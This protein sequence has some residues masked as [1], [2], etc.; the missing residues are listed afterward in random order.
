MPSAAFMADKGRSDDRRVIGLSYITSMPAK[1]MFMKG[2][3]LGAKVLA[4]RLL[5]LKGDSYVAYPQQNLLALEM[6][7]D[8]RTIQRYISELCDAGLIWSIRSGHGTT[9]RYGF[10]DHEAW[11]WTEEDAAAVRLLMA[12]H[13]AECQRIRLAGT[14]PK[15]ATKMSQGC[16]KNVAVTKMS[17]LNTRQECRLIDHQHLTGMSVDGTS[18]YIPGGSGIENEKLNPP[19]CVNLA[20][21][22]V[23]T[24]GSRDLDISFSPKEN[25][26]NTTNL[27]GNQAIR[28]AKPYATSNISEP[29]GFTDPVTLSP[30]P[31]TPLPAAAPLTG[32]EDES[33]EPQLGFSRWNRTKGLP[34]LNAEAKRWIEHV[35]EQGV[36]DIPWST[37]EA[38]LEAFVANDEMKGR[39]YPYRAFWKNPAAWAPNRQES[40]QNAPGRFQG[41]RTPTPPPSAAPCPASASAVAPYVEMWNRDNPHSE[42]DATIANSWDWKE[43]IGVELF[44]KEFSRIAQWCGFLRDDCGLTHVNLPW[45]LRKQHGVKKRNWERLIEG[46]FLP[47][48][49]SRY[50]QTREDAD[51]Q[52][53]DSDEVFRDLASKKLPPR[54]PEEIEIS[55]QKDIERK[56]KLLAWMAECRAKTEAKRQAELRAVINSP[57][58]DPFAAIAGIDAA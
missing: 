41:V 32:Y 56:A 19:A 49:W 23:A 18:D 9:G 31:P 16:D 35:H 8:V 12:K 2:I 42:T 7:V 11:Q 55:R 14:R 40:R 53:R 44:R 3:S 34:K 37:V 45:V 57:D 5:T 46:D 29:E 30:L 10:H 20:I 39:S 4:A 15:G 58:Y 13:K 1:L 28:E 36:G 25:Q 33:W 54:T 17:P 24:N 22:S 50:P 27:K 38:A 48:G 51:A 21:P 43:C 47:T 52:K 6:D 26:T